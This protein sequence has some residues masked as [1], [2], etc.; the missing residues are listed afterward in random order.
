LDRG[1]KGAILPICAHAFKH[2]QRLMPLE[3]A[4]KMF[5]NFIMEKV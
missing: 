5:A 4:E 3:T 1:L 2:P